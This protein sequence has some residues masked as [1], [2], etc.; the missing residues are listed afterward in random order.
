MLSA[1]ISE[2]SEAYYSEELASGEVT[3]NRKPFKGEHS[4][5][6]LPLSQYDLPTKNAAVSPATESTPAGEPL[7][8]GRL[9]VANS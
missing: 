4:V 3:P 6:P 9:V 8:N 1:G 2:T 7:P 5:S